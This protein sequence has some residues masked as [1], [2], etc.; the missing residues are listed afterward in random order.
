VNKEASHYMRLFGGNKIGNLIFLLSLVLTPHSTVLLEKLT[1][2]QQVKKFPAFY[3][4]RT[5]IAASTS[6]CQ[7]SVS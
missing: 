5:F 2:L 3:G 7:M 4:T 1:G 6:A